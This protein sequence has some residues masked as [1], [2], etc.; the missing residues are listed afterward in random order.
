MCSYTG[1]SEGSATSVDGCR[2][3]F[4]CAM[5]HANFLDRRLQSYCFTHRVSSFV[6]STGSI[7]K[8]YMGQYLASCSP[9]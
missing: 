6:L 4:D 7:D 2:V 8:V 9:S 5:S 3:S 1:R